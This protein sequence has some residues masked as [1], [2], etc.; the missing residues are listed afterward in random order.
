MCM[1]VR[2]LSLCAG[3]ASTCNFRKEDTHFCKIKLWLSARRFKPRHS[4]EII[5]VHF[6]RKP[7]RRVARGGLVSLLLLSGKLLLYQVGF[8]KG[9]NEVLRVK[10]TDERSEGGHKWSGR[11]DLIVLP[12]R[13]EVKPFSRHK[14]WAL[15]TQKLLV[16]FMCP[17]VCAVAY[18]ASATFDIY[19]RCS[20]C[21]LSRRVSG[22]SAGGLCLSACVEAR[23]FLFSFLKF[24]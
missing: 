9:R 8:L 23:N 17:R 14:D 10:E 16:L 18:C 11:N 15:C 1:C 19:L 7:V 12:S 5:S 6:A 13:E 4:S 24:F 22:I 21:R 20:S 3:V 2:S